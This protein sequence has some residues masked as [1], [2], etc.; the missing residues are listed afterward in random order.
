V[1]ITIKGIRVDTVSLKLDSENGGFDIESAGYSL[2][3]STDHVL[4]KQ[5]IGGYGSIT[6]KPSPETR[7]AMDTFM[8]NY[9]KDV[10]AVLGLDLETGE[11][12]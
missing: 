9:K 10:I 11:Q 12:Q 6:L 1:A 4:A 3:S 8:A 5:S 7:K 2:I